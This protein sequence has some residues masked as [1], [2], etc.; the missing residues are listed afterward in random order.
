MKWSYLW[1]KAFIA[2][3]FIREYNQQNNWILSKA[4]EWD[5]T[6]K[7]KCVLFTSFFF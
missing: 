1:E 7:Y 3:D 2:P 4:G 5:S 6:K